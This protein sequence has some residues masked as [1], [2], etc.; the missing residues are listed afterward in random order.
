MDNEKYWKVVC[1]YGHVGKK[2][3]IS[4]SRYLRTNTDLNLI[5][6]L[7]IVAQMPGVKKGSNVIHSIDTARPISKTE[8]EEGKKEEKNNFFLQKLMNFKKQNKAKEIA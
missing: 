2:R 7:E 8:Y 5:E 1:R 4:V 3:Y 6:V